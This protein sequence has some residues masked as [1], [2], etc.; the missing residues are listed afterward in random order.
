VSPFEGI[1]CGDGHDSPYQICTG[2]FATE[3]LAGFIEARIE[4]GLRA[5]RLSIQFPEFELRP[6]GVAPTYTTT[7][8]SVNVRNRERDGSV[9]LT[10]DVEA[11]A[12]ASLADSDRTDA[13][14]LKDKAIAHIWVDFVAKRVGINLLPEDRKKLEAM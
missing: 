2:L 7:D 1:G 13:S 4:A 12:E 10:A 11:D 3:P 14:D 5:T 6:Y 8:S 9:T